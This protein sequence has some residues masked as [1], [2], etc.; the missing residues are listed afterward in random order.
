[1]GMSDNAD[2]APENSEIVASESSGNA[3]DA[4]AQD[5]LNAIML[6]ESVS[7]I[8]S[9]WGISSVALGQWLDENRKM[10]ESAFSAQ[11]L[12]LRAGAT[13]VLLSSLTEGHD[14][15]VT[16]EEVY[17]KDG[18]LAGTRKTVSRSTRAP[19]VAAA[20]FVAERLDPDRFGDKRGDAPD[21]MDSVQIVIQ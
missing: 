13:R 2:S 7:D 6:G 18:L 11:E 3:L 8:A 12:V 15:R 16:T 5:I 4:H 10:V 1:M 21:N 19:S 9:R 17:D 20:K 14:E